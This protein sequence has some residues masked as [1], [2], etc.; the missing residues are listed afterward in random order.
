MQDQF[1]SDSIVS[2]EEEIEDNEYLNQSRRPI[3]L[4]QGARDHFSKS[5]LI[6][7]QD[8]MIL[9]DEKEHKMLKLQRKE[10]KFQ[11]EPPW[12]IMKV[13]LPTIVLY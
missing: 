6:L 8:L 10:S 12:Y 3:K 13:Q 1:N 9:T 4:A 11:W 5:I 2:S 7:N